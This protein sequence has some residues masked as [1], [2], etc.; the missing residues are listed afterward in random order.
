MVRE[1]TTKGFAGGTGSKAA[2]MDVPFSRTGFSREGVGAN[3]IN[4]STGRPVGAGLLANL[5]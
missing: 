4:C 3:T 2:W 5:V 1:L